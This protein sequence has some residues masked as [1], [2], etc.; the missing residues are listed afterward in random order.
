VHPLLGT[1]TCTVGTIRGGVT[2]NVTP[3]RCEAEI[4]IR[5]VPGQDYQ[6]VIRQ[7]QELAGDK[8]EI[9]L[10]DW[11]E[12][13]E[14]SPKEEFVK[15]SL[16]AVEQVTGQA[17][18]AMGVSYYTDAAILANRLKIPFVNIGPADTGE[19]HQP[20]EHVEVSRLVDAVKIYLL[21][22]ARYLG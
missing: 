6:A 10:I 9:T 15:I 2:I 7:V 19:T 21:I 5:L 3:D 18:A 4:D 14:T 12:P 20:N 16:A 1:G 22:A 8:V 17:R 13:V 11:K